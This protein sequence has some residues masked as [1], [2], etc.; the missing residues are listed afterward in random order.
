MICFYEDFEGNFQRVKEPINFV[1]NLAGEFLREPVA[2]KVLQ[3][4]WKLD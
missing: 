4:D 3:Q 2:P 1:Y